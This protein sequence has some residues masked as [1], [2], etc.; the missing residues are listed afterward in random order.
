[1]LFPSDYKEQLPLPLKLRNV[2]LRTL[3]MHL[4]EPSSGLS[5]RVGAKCP[6]LLESL[7]NRSKASGLSSYPPLVSV[8]AWI[9][10]VFQLERIVLL[11]PNLGRIL[12]LAFLK[13]FVVL[14]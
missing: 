11:R 12:L 5:L 6:L 7:G 10:T 13:E 9:V 1:M 2:P 4:S 3:R 14:S 8:S